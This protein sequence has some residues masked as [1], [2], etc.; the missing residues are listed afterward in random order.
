MFIKAVPVWKNV[1]D[2][3]EKLN[4]HLIF[5][6]NAQSLTGCSLKIAA[7]DWYKLYVNGEYVGSGPARSA[8]GYG[9]VDEYDLSV[10]IVLLLM[11]ERLA[12]VMVTWV[13]CFSEKNQSALHSW[14]VTSPLLLQRALSVSQR[15]L[16][17][18][19]KNLSE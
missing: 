14:Q 7:A 13:L 6:E 19:E 11:T 17:R 2:Y 12:S 4:T 9:R 16:T 8:V 3:K 1:D 10:S 5:R 15:V 18:L